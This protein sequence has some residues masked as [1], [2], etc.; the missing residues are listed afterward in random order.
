MACFEESGGG[1]DV[2]S[3]FARMVRR[4]LPALLLYARSLSRGVSTDDAEDWVQ[5]AFLRLWERIR[6]GET[7]ERPTFWLYRV[8]RNRSIDAVRRAAVHRRW[9]EESREG[10]S[11]RFSL[12]DASSVE[13]RE[14]IRRLERGL[15]ALPPEIREIVTTKIWG[16]LSFDD[17]AELTGAARTTLF[18]RFQKGVTILRRFWDHD[19]G[20][21]EKFEK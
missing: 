5:D 7:P 4:D 8:V 10:A 15:A 3:D 21:N 2:R 12:P 16:D 19:G 6:V 11:I 1:A 20:D 9:R 18:D 14:E 17:L 13:T